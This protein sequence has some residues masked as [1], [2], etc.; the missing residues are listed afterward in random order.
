MIVLSGHKKF[1][2]GTKRD[3]VSFFLEFPISSG[4]SNARDLF[5]LSNLRGITEHTGF[6]ETITK[7]NNLTPYP[8]SSHFIH[9][10]FF[11]LKQ[12]NNAYV[13]IKESSLP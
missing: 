12:L 3:K 10:E 7:N 9:N 2:H 13:K 1:K 8:Y 6:H 4:T 5:L 11:I